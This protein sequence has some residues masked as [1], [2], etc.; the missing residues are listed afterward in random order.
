M[1]SETQ[2][3]GPVPPDLYARAAA[4]YY[5]SPHDPEDGA[6]MAHHSYMAEHD[7]RQ[8]LVLANPR[9]FLA[10]YRIRTSGMLKK[11]RRWPKAIEDGRP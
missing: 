10:V 11:L 7:G 1:S 9:A 5:R 3:L 8:Y 2:H 6:P 4:A